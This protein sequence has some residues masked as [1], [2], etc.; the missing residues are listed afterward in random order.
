ML[1]QGLG[2]DCARRQPDGTCTR[3]PLPGYFA[4]RTAVPSFTLYDEAPYSIAVGTANPALL[5]MRADVLA[6]LI[7]A[8]WIPGVWFRPSNPLTLLSQT[9]GAV[10]LYAE[11]GTLR[12]PAECARLKAALR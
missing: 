1:R 3:R 4:F 9:P 12:S 11:P 6:S 5:A 10:W 7:H 2:E 8:A